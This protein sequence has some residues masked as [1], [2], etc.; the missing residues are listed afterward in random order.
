MFRALLRFLERFEQPTPEARLLEEAR[1]KA[2][3]SEPST[4]I[5]LVEA[6]YMPHGG[7]DRLVLEL[8]AGETG[9]VERV[10]TRER[11]EPERVTRE[12]PLDE[13]ARVLA[14]LERRTIWTLQ[15]EQERIIDGLGAHFA[16]ARGA[17][18]HGVRLHSGHGTQLPLEQ[19][20]RL[21]LELAPL[22]EPL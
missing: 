4:L 20:L 1:A 11:R 22:A 2:L 17:Q 9:Q 3:A 19:L 14:E 6:G 13:A 5:V 7:R 21:L 18:A 16:F 8:P 15:D 12:L 10:R